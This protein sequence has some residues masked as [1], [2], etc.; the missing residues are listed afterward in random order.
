MESSPGHFPA[1]AH[2]VQDKADNVH[3]GLENILPESTA[4]PGLQAHQKEVSNDMSLGQA[5]PQHGS[6]HTKLG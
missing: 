2:C 4:A 1:S 5:R 3:L 6:F